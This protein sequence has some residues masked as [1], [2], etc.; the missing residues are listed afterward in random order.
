MPDEKKDAPKGIIATIRENFR[1]FTS[2][3]KKEETK[4][5]VDTSR[6]SRRPL[7]P[8]PNAQQLA[9]TRKA[10]EGR[11]QTSKRKDTARR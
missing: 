4:K 2:L 11:S 6:V 7:R 5:P 8:E 10:R 9:A 3:G 1:K